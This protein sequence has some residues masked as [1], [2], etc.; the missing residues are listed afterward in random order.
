MTIDKAKILD[1]ILLKFVGNATIFWKDLQQG[2]WDDIA[3]YHVC[4]N[5]INFLV[6][7][8]MLKR[9]TVLESLSMTNKG[10]ATMTDLDNLGYVKKATKERQETFLKYGLAFVTVSTF[11]ILCLKTFIWNGDTKTYTQTE[12]IQDSVRPQ[13]K[14]KVDETANHVADSV[15]TKQ[16]TI[17]KTQNT[18]SITKY[19][20]K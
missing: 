16:D 17:P 11:V 6:G 10:F 1:S 9:D 8:D 2:I 3:S 20:S 7:D 4:E 19:I 15:S 18:D 5:N 13:E 12:S 14:L